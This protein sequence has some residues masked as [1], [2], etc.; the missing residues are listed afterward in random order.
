MPGK[1]IQFDGETLTALEALA[2]DSM[3]TFQELSDEAFRDLLKKHGRPDTLK[4]ALRASIDQ[5][6]GPGQRTPRKK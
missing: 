3:K 1:R 5:D 6:A 4:K 2:S